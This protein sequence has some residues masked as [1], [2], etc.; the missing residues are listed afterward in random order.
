MAE[1]ELA[2]GKVTIVI[3]VPGAWPD[4]AA[5]VRA[6]TENNLNELLMA[7]KI[8]MRLPTRHG[9]EF[10]VY[11][12]DPNLRR[13][14]AVAGEAWITDAELAQIDAHTLTVYALG[15]GGNLDNAR[16]MM[17]VANGLLNAGGLAVKVESAGKAFRRGDWARMC[18][19][20]GPLVLYDAYVTFALGRGIAYSC[21]MHNL[22]Y[23]DAVVEGDLGPDEAVGLLDAFLKYL[24]V[25]QPALAEGHIFSLAPDAPAYRL[26]LI[27]CTF[28]APDDPFYNPFG[29]WVLTPDRQD[30]K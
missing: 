14:F 17:L 11:D 12:H 16:E 13:A 21:G 18:Q 10:E 4:R 15:P 8:I 19:G 9:F 6:M 22:G 30:K 29:F 1:V 25:E 7:G 26:S 20:R 2:Q 3:G 24:L 23:H 28:Y 5:L 27:P